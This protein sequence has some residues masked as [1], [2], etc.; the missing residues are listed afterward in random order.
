MGQRRLSDAE[1]ARQDAE[2]IER[3]SFG[4]HPLLQQLAQENALLSNELNELATQVHEI[5]VDASIV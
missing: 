1:N 2:E 4:K 5:N 3:L